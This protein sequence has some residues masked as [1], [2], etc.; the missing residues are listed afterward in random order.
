MHSRLLFLYPDRSWKP[1]PAR[2]VFLWEE[3]CFS[4]DCLDLALSPAKAFPQTSCSDI[5]HV[6]C[7]IADYYPE[8][9]PESDIFDVYNER[10]MEC[11]FLKNPELDI[12][13]MVS[14]YATCIGSML[15][16]DGGLLIR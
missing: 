3:C 14:G 15:N 7:R 11:F 6:K 2:F 8:N 12:K 16:I 9:R 13:K 1:F 10:D 4:W 5:Y